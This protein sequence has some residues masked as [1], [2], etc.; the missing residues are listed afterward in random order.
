MITIELSGPPKGKGRGRAVAIPGRGA[1]IYS[2]PNTVKYE[3]QIRHA[4][5]QAMGGR[6][7]IGGPVQVVMMV[8]F[9]VPESWSKKK[10]ALA[11]AGGI[12]PTVK[13]DADNSLKLT[14]AL[15]FVCWN[16]DKQV[17]DAR[18]IKRYS[19]R[20]GMTIQITELLLDKTVGLYVR[21]SAGARAGSMPGPAVALPLFPTQEAADKEL[22]PAFVAPF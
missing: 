2:D 9:P 10:R 19:D 4:A 6:P 22:G 20:P 17:V 12:L 13:P 15:N 14:D 21:P 1:R 7:P 16:D 18:V 8:R 11:L 5:T 3:S